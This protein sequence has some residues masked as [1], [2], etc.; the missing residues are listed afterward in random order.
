M[1][2]FCCRYVKEISSYEKEAEQQRQKVKKL[3]ESGADGHTVNKQ[4]EVLEETQQMIPECRSL[5][6]KALDELEMLVVR[7]ASYCSLTCINYFEAKVC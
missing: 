3:E 6:E 5:L 4:K 7:P 2:T 1:F